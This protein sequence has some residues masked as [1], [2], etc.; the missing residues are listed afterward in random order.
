[1]TRINMILTMVPTAACKTL[2]LFEKWGKLSLTISAKPVG[3]GA[4]LQPW[5]PAGEQYGLLTRIAA[6]ESVLLCDR[7]KLTAF[8]ALES[9]IR[10]ASCRT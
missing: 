7:M 3:V 10:A 5:I 1:M 6:T 2:V 8:V 9:A 4:V